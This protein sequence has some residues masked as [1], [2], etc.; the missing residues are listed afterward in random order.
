MGHP[1]D[2]VERRDAEERELVEARRQVDER[3]DHAGHRRHGG[4][5]VEGPVDRGQ[6]VLTRPRLAQVDTEH[7]GERA[8]RGDQEREHQALGAERLRAEDQRGDQHH[9]VRLEQVGGHAGAVADVVADVVGD[10]GGVARVVLGDV[11]LDLAHQVGADVG[12]LGEDAAADPHEHRE[13]GG[14]ESEALEH[15]RGLVAE[16][17]D[18]DGGTEQAEADGQHADRGAGAEADP[19]GGVAALLVGRGGDS[20][21]GPHGE[22]HA[23]VADRAGEAGADEEEHGAEDPDREIVGGQ[24]QQEQECH[25]CEH[26]EGAELPGQIGV[27]ALLHRMRDVL[28]VVG[29]FTGGKDLLAEHVRHPERAERDQ[30]DDDDQHEV[31][32]GEMHDSGTDPGHGS[33]PG[34]TNLRPTARIVPCAPGIMSDRSGPSHTG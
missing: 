16:G 28:H 1:D 10:G 13:Q 11:L 7:G 6:A 14:T 19:H 25:H 26:R 22:V 15:G 18:D 27:R 12:R 5:D 17:D 32:P 33:P 20:E 3:E 34:N 23:E 8:D 24:R 9:G 31:A 21:V 29:A 4:G 2:P 30:E